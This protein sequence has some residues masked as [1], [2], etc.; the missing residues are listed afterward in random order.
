MEISRASLDIIVKHKLDKVCKLY[1][2][3]QEQYKE[4]FEKMNLFDSD[5]NWMVQI[6]HTK[7]SE[8]DGHDMSNLNR[9]WKLYNTYKKE[10][11][12]YD[13]W[14]EID[15]LLNRDMK[16]GAIKLYRQEFGCGLREAKDVIDSRQ[17][18]LKGQI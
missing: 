3:I 11:R 9:V 13:E 18:K 14:S 17:M 2:E 12:V 16:I 5:W 8:I 15:D 7:P 10:G 1:F 4:E 6:T